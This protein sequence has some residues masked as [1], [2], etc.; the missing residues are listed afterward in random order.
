MKDLFVVVML[1]DVEEEPSFSFCRGGGN[2][3]LQQVKN[4]WRAVQLLEAYDNLAETLSW[5]FDFSTA[6]HP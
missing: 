6:Y 3:C 4:F 5:V 1:L 2:F